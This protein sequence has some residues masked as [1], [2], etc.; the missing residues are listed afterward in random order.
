MRSQLRHSSTTLASSS[1][2]ALL[3]D[4]CIGRRSEEIADDALSA[5]RSLRAGKA[6]AKVGFGKRRVRASEGLAV[7]HQEM[8]DDRTQ[9]QRRKVS[10]QPD[11][12]DDADQQADE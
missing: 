12:D 2:T 5:T 8:L 3:M 10:Q 6:G 11:D 4:S 1:G 7:E 9:R